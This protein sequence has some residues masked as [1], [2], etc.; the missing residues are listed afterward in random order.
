MNSGYRNC[1]CTGPRSILNQLWLAV[2]PKKWCWADSGM[3]EKIYVLKIN[4]S[5][6][7]VRY[8]FMNHNYNVALI[9]VFLVSPMQTASSLLVTS[10]TTIITTITIIT[11]TTLRDIFAPLTTVT[12]LLPVAMQQIT[13]LSLLSHP[14]QVS[15]VAIHHDQSPSHWMWHQWTYACRT[16][17]SLFGQQA[18]SLPL[19][20]RA[21]RHRLC[22]L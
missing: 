4:L 9:S 1:C 12:V 20:G 8:W 18:V 17:L 14:G 11:T 7:E 5:V 16:C 15:T 2:R 13:I 6:G 21:R 3:C 10:N 22:P 19:E